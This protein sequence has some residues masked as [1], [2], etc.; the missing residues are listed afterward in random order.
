MQKYN[1]KS[2]GSRQHCIK[3]SAAPSRLARR[4]PGEG[5]RLLQAEARRDPAAHPVSKAWRE[6]RLV[7]MSR[8]TLHSLYVE[9]MFWTY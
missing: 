3:P 6:N 5:K 9:G 8:I 1:H 4:L 2:F 7:S